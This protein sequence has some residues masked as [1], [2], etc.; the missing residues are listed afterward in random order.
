MIRP[1]METLHVE[2]PPRRLA[3]WAWVLIYAAAMLACGLAG[4]LIGTAMVGA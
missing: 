2:P 1:D 3:W 4:A